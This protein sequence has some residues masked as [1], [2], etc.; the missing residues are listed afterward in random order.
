VT[1][2]RATV[3][4][5]LLTLAC[6][7][8]SQEGTAQA[9]GLSA[10]EAAAG[11]RLLF[12]GATTNGWRGYRTE[13]APAGW[14]VNE[15]ELTFAVVEDGR[16]DLVTTETFDSFELRLEW[17][18]AEGGNSG[19]FFHV[20]EDHDWP[21][22]SGP[23]MQILDD[24][25]HVDGQSLLTSAGSNYALHGVPKGAS[26]PA[27]EWNSVRL[28][29]DGDHVVHWL[30]DVKVVEY[31]LGLVR[32]QRTAAL[33][34]GISRFRT[35]AIRCGTG[36]SASGSWTSPFPAAPDSEDALP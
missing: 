4:L 1:A 11:F 35:M 18:V 28:I 25:N 13:V 29:V 26:H 27:G 20:T 34:R 31:T 14:S 12:D 8:G 32:C 15:G 21:W 5:L 16:G 3:S 6:G 10:D 22:E 19:I 23:E 30:N 2:P 7:L 17:K 24:A 9:A 36:T 33:E